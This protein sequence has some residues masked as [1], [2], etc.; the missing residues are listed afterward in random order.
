M[1]LKHALN[2]SLQKSDTWC[3]KG[4]IPGST[5]TTFGVGR[6]GISV[7]RLIP[8]Y[9]VSALVFA[10][11]FFSKLSQRLM[12]ALHPTPNL[13]SDTIQNF[14]LLIKP[15]EGLLDAVLRI[16]H[17][18]MWITNSDATEQLIRRLPS[19]LCAWPT[20]YGGMDVIANRVTPSHCD[21]GSA[22]SFYDH[23]LSLGQDHDAKLKLDD[24]G[25]EFEYLPG[26]G[27]WLTGRGL[28]HSVPPWTQGERVV[29][30]HYSKDDVL[31]RLGIPRP[32]L[33]VQAKW[34]SEYLLT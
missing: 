33:P 12:D 31:D 24:L 18:E 2:N 20:V 21:G 28:S 13:K 5:E 16:I 22:F 17:P 9:K 23:L 8:G 27:V 7:G 30:A 29:I 1:T 4:F 15:L 11:N 3:A 19:P 6:I 14:L 26:T 32:S 10:Y 34:L 25:A